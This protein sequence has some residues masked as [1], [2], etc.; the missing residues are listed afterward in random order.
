[1]IQRLQ[2]GQTISDQAAWA[3]RLAEWGIWRV[4]EKVVGKGDGCESAGDARVL[5]V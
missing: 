2:Q 4:E 5:K 3:R 1:M